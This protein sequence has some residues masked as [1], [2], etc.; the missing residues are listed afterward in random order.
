MGKWSLDLNKWSKLQGEK[1]NE[2]RRIFAFEV[3]NKVILESPVDTGAFRG[4]WGV[5]IG[6]DE[7]ND[8]G[9]SDKSGNDTIARNMAAA[10]NLTGDDSIFIYNNL[11]YGRKIEYGTFTKKPETEK[12]I[13]GFSKQAPR[14]MVG[15]TLAKAEQ[16]WDKAVKAVKDNP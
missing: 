12:T 15:K 7:I 9:S 5:S 2:V 16:L 4:A 13:G 11:P 10:E 14:G 8:T 1:L 6:R 3:F